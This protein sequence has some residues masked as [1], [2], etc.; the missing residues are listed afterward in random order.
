MLQKGRS[1]YAE[2]GYNPKDFKPRVSANSVY[3]IAGGKKLAVIK[4]NMDNSIRSI[5]VMGIK[6]TELHRV[7]CIRASNHDIRVWSGE[8]GNEIRKTFGV[9]VQP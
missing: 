5:T 7:S 1:K 3:V 6:G 4:V 8:C 2:M 9:S